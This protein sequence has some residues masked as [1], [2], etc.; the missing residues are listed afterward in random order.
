LV[1]LLPA[2]VACAPVLGGISEVRPTMEQWLATEAV[3]NTR[4][5]SLVA[6]ACRRECCGVA[7]PDAQKAQPAEIA[8]VLE[9]VLWYSS[10]NGTYSGTMVRV[11]EYRY[12]R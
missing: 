12:Q 2:G 1:Q 4:L 10:T 7:A 8:M 11:L 5:C 3:K 9:Y 6:L